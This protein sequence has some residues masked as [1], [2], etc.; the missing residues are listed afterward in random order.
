MTPPFKIVIETQQ[1]ARSMMKA[2]F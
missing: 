2:W 1:K